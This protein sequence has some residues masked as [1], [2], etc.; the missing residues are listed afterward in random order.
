MRFAKGL[1]NFTMAYVPIMI[2]ICPIM[3]EHI[4]ITQ[5]KLAFIEHYTYVL[6]VGIKYELVHSLA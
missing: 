5:M 4:P 2:Y 3:S 6:C 1:A